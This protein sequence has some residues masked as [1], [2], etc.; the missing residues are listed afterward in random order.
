MQEPPTGCRVG[1]PATTKRAWTL[2][3]RATERR[4]RD[5]PPTSQ[6]ALSRERVSKRSK[7]AI[8][9]ASATESRLRDPNRL[10]K[11]AICAV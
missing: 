4:L 7:A 2:H 5:A 8:E 6:S 10:A 1:V 9:H 3:A 11:G